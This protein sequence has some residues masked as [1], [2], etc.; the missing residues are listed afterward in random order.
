MERPDEGKLQ[1]YVEWYFN[2]SF[3]YNLYLILKIFLSSCP[4]ASPEFEGRGA[5]YLNVELARFL[6]RIFQNSPSFNLQSLCVV[7]GQTCWVL[8]IFLLHFYYLLFLLSNIIII[9]IICYLFFCI[10]YLKIKDIDALVLDSGGNLFDSLSLATLA[11]LYNTKIPSIKVD[12]LQGDASEG[13]ISRRISLILFY[14]YYFKI[15]YS[16][17]LFIVFV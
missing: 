13:N 16:V 2:L 7:P 9:T 12:N 8:C 11:A 10:F 4:S 3:T 6:E 5:E 15:Y 14:Y 17:Y 1:F